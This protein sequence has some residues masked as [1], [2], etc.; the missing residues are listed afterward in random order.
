MYKVYKLSNG[1][2]VICEYID[3]VHSVS[4]GVFIRSGS[5]NEPENLAG[6]SHFIEHML[7]K[8]TEN[9]SAFEIAEEMDS[10]GGCLNAYTTKEHT[11][12]YAKMLK[13]NVETAIDVLSDMLIR[14][15]LSE[16]DIELEKN[17]VY[18]EINMY[19]DS[20]EELVHEVLLEAMWGDD[21]GLGAPV[22]GNRKSLEKI[23]RQMILEYM[24]KMYTPSNC[25]ISVAGKFD[26]SLPDMLER[27]FGVWD[28]DNCV[29][30][31]F[32]ER[33]EKN[34]IIRKKD[35]EQVHFCIGFPA[36]AAENIK[37]YPLL[38]FNN[39]FGAAMS[40]TLFQK[41][42]EQ[43]GL[44]YS[45]YSYINGFTDSG[46]FVIN[47]SVK[48]DNLDEVLE[49]VFEETAAAKNKEFDEKQIYKAKQQIKGSYILGLESASARMQSIGRAMLMLDRV[50]TPE[51][52][53]ES[54][55]NVNAESAHKCVDEVINFGN[56][57]A[58]MIGN[59]EKNRTAF[60]KWIK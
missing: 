38:A 33:Y 49:I 42:R 10:S 51:E 29:A 25:V 4:V 18:E 41:V 44:A 7:F 27:Y 57:S 40:S 45:I 50:K 5:R 22:L 52:I 60:E 3:Y 17:V 21:S 26:D 35:V 43:R 12:F 30:F 58:C 28:N 46:I 31:G 34:V 15:K 59:V 14:P 56:M 23:N 55:D 13:E 1:I 16:D 6:I 53:I 32:E 19:E 8:G 37:N 24:D 36:Y 47:A 48:P 54:I 9:R 20:P 39:M 2:R 11:C